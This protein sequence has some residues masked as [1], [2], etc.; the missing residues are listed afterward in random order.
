[1]QYSLDLLI[2]PTRIQICE[3]CHW[4]SEC[5]DCC[6]ACKNPCNSH[7]VC[8]LKENH[9]DNADRYEAWLMLISEFHNGDS[10]FY[11]K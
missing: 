5:K 8:A 4:S 10:K 6:S 3:M 7:Q 11:L 2:V 1:M 9:E